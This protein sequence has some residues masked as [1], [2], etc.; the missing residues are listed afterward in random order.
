MASSFTA[1]SII[2]CFIKDLKIRIIRLFFN[3]QLFPVYDE[4]VNASGFGGTCG[5]CDRD[6]VP[7]AQEQPQIIN[8][9]VT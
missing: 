7:E 1:V 9:S 4:T 8:A 2:L 6:S 3:R 5:L